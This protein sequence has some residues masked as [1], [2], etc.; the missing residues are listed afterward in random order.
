MHIQSLNVYL[1]TLIRNSLGKKEKEQKQNLHTRN[2][3]NVFLIISNGQID[4]KY[5]LFCTV[6]NV[7]KE[8]EKNWHLLK[9]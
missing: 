9:E 8:M 2:C 4:S 3:L 7:K 1:N 5:Y 6:K